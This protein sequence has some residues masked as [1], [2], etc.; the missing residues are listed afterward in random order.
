[1][2]VGVLLILNLIKVAPAQ[3]R[4]EK[5]PLVNRCINSWVM[6]KQFVHDASEYVASHVL[7]IAW[8]HYHRVDLQRL[9]AGVAN[10]TDP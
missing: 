1:M 9:E 3:P 8:S 2:A 7:A 4:A 10:D 5:P 6:F